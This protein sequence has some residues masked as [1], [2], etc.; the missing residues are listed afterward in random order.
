MAAEMLY[1]DP[2]ACVDCGA[3]VDVC[4]VDAIVPEHRL[5]T[6]DLPF[7]QINAQYFTMP[8]RRDYPPARRVQST[9]E[10]TES[11]ILRIAIV[12]SGPSACYAA[13]HLLSRRGLDVEVN[14]FERMPT[15]WGLVRSGVAPDHPETKAVIRTFERL[16]TL[17]ANFFFDVEVGVHLTQQELLSH[18]HAVIYAVGASDNR[19]LDV[20]GS[21]LGGVHFARDFVGWYNGDPDFHD[22]EFD[23][24]AEQAVVVGNGNVALD[25]A[26][27]LAAD[28][29]DLKRTD[30]ADHALAALASSKIREITVLGRRTAAQ[31]AYTTPELLS[32]TL[33]PGFDI[34]VDSRE[35]LLD[36]S[37]RS[38]LAGVPGSVSSVKLGLAE[39]LGGAPRRHEKRVHLRFL[40]SPT[41]LL[42]D[43]SVRAVRLERKEPETAADGSIRIVSTGSTE[44]ID[45][46][47]VLV[48]IGS[49]ATPLPGLPFDSRRG[50]VPSDSG[51]VIET[52][53]QT[54]M[55]R[56]Y[57]VGWIKRGATAVIGT[58]KSC[59]EETVS[60][61]VDD[62]VSGRLAP[63][64]S[65]DGSLADFVSVRQ[66][67]S[68][69]YEGWRTIDRH[70]RAAG[71]AIGRPRLKL[72][73]RADLSD[74][75]LAGS[76]AHRR[77]RDADHTIGTA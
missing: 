69:G 21:D 45:G 7:A 60:S 72:V 42:G 4:P 70:E 48:S 50:V 9:S 28:P 63:P 10:I 67:T 46:G 54:A 66:P 43:G 55:L 13:K 23:L 35:V 24:S 39:R 25:V 22:V 59:A 76:T 74:V 75:A 16:A 8:G 57:V 37:V 11:E 65:P 30:I 15:P 33:I 18:H 1:I 41:E 49:V 29:D 64:S 44:D 17:G 20:P 56:R 6:G 62:F 14:V 3:C 40:A 12:G 19:P 31:A 68:F 58:N 53:S 77:H 52:R 61:L 36:E 73:D 51:R 27:I 71:Q 5:T 26:R 34:G 38:V 2:A 47:L 32:L